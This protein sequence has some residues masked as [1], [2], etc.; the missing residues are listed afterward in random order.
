MNLRFELRHLRYFV[1]VAEEL[2]FRRA[3]ERLFISQPPLSRQIRE[4]E[5]ALGVRLLARDTSTVRLTPAGEAAYRDAKKLLAEAEAFGERMEALRQEASSSVR[6]AASVAIPIAKHKPLEAAWRQSLDVA[7]LQI[8]FAESKKLL[9]Q[10]RQGQFD[11]GLLG[12][13]ADFRGLEHELVQTL[14]LV[15]TLSQDHPAAK[16]RSVSLKDM[17]GTPLFW[18]QRGYN[19]DYFDHCAAEFD[20]I[21]FRPEY[22][23]VAP[24]QLVT[25][26]RISH[27]EGFSLL[28]IAQTEMKIRGVVHRPLKEG[29]A[30]GISLI[31]AWR[32]GAD[33]DHA[34]RAQRFVAATRKVLG[35]TR[36]RP[37][38]LAP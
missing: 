9:P 20:R 17:Q 25:L 35:V 2:N 16:R 18:F 27:G 28:S 1:A 5:S 34:A 11:L 37:E 14:P 19:P 3:A 23:Y 21:G 8:E 24:G 30:L 12:G 6:V 7:N 26:E 29:R 36:A 13:P 22:V 38:A 4:L 10:L 31:A 33:P 15:V 32:A